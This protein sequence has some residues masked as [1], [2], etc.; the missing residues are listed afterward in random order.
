MKIITFL[1]DFG[2]WSPSGSR[3]M[4]HY[5]HVLNYDFLKKLKESGELVEFLIVNEHAVQ[6]V[7]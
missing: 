4:S 5:E 3:V 6:V 2:S 1:T 7:G